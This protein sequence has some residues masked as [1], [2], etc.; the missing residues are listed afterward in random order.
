MP[1][2]L[3]EPGRLEPFEE[4]A[5]IVAEHPGG[6]LPRATDSELSDL[7]GPER[8]QCVR[9]RPRSIGAGAHARLGTAYH[10]R[11]R[12]EPSAIRSVEPGLSRAR[13]RQAG[14]PQHVAA[15]RPRVALVG[16]YAR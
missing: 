2:G 14:R 5:T 3:L 16:L 4:G 12:G 11:L 7:H 15:R 8:Y 9:D 10:R 6:E 13:G 1:H